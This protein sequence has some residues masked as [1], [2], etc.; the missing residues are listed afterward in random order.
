MTDKIILGIREGAKLATSEIAFWFYIKHNR[1]TLFSLFSL[2]LLGLCKHRM[3]LWPTDEPGHFLKLAGT[4]RRADFF[5][6]DVAF[7][8]FLTIRVNISI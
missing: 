3:L 8:A 5:R 2:K 7:K 6:L 1:F 4:R